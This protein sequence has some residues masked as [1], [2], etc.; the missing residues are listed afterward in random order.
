MTDQQRIRLGMIGSAVIV[1][2][3]LFGLSFYIYHRWDTGSEHTS[4]FVD[5][6]TGEVVSYQK[7]KSTEGSAGGEQLIIL[8][9]S[10]VSDHGATSEQYKLI[11]QALIDYS[12]QKLNNSFRTIT[13]IP[14]SFNAVDNGIV[15]KLRLGQGGRTVTATIKFWDLKYAQLQIGDVENSNGS[16]D[17]GRLTIPGAAYEGTD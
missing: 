4:S 10:V 8:G 11:K 12:K 6:D 9:S 15:G 3:T 7:N 5:K 1:L 13:L 14:S 16:Y 2:G 17:S